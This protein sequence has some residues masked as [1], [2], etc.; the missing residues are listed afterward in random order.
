MLKNVLAP[1]WDQV[2]HVWSRDIF[3]D[4]FPDH[5]QGPCSPEEYVNRSLYFEARTFLH[6]LFVVE[7]KLSMAHSLETRVPFMDNDLVDFAMRLPVKFKL[8]NLQEVIKL[9]ENEPSGK[10]HKYFHKTRD[11]KLLLR[12]MMQKYVPGDIANGV[13]QGFSSPDQSW[14]K[15]ESIEFVKKRILSQDSPIYNY[16]DPQSVRDMVNEHIE[17]RKNRRLF[18]WSLIN[19][20]QW[21]RT[22]EIE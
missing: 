15:G 16:F 14:F 4:V 11:G 17:G 10:R 9:D 2:E 5:D 18:I 1:I 7:D 6:G 20:D 13:K 22:F 19:F 3:K 21:L 8:G 12:K